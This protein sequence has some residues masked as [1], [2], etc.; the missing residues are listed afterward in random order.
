MQVNPTWAEKV[1]KQVREGYEV[2]RTIAFNKAAQYLIQI[3]TKYNRPF[4]IYNLGAGV[5]RIT[6]NTDTCP[7][8]KRRL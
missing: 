4:K 8:C 3:L 6:T 1:A 7:C 5:K 2:D